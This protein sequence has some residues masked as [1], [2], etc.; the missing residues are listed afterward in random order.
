MTEA[1]RSQADGYVKWVRSHVGHELIYLVYTTTLVFD[2]AGRLLVQRR[3]DFDW[4]GVPGGALEL[5]ESL[6]DCAV[7]ETREETGLHVTIERLVGVFSHPRFNL[8]Y[9]NG[10]QVQQ[11]SVCV[12]GRVAG[13]TLHAD[14][15]ETLDVCW[16]PVDEAMPQLPPVYRAMVRA[17]LESPGRAVLEPVYSQPALTPHFP[18]LRRHIDHDPI[19]LPGAMGVI[20]NEAGHVLVARRNVEQVFDIPGGFADLGET[21]TATI[22]REMREETGLHVKPVRMIG[23]YSAGMQSSYPNGD[24]THGV[25]AAFECRV[26][27]G[28]L[29]ADHDE[30]SE[31]RYM[32]LSELL[33]QDNVNTRP[34]GMIQLWRDIEHPDQWPFIR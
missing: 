32:S 15:G 34:P 31:L 27:G 5:G 28:T 4:L 19:I 9:P 7:R 17:A 21:T 20:R 10:D 25:G 2:D 11:W 13:G 24:Q 8:L 16:M 33:A 12:A 3:Y 1:F 6:H 23:V 18:I 29:H 22:V 30:I 14:G 26:V